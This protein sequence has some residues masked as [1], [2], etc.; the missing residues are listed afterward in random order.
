MRALRAGEAG[1][2]TLEAAKRKATAIM[3]MTIMG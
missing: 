2:L 1:Y 3:M